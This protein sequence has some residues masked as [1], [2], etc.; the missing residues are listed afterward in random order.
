MDLSDLN[1]QQRTAVE[2]DKGPILVV[3]G[4]G[5]GKTKVITR[6]IAY[7]IETE[8]AKPHEIL[9]LTFTDKAARE[10]EER[11]DTLLPYGLVDTRIM[12]FHSFGQDL[13]KDYGLE[14][15][16]SPNVTL[17][18]KAQQIVFLKDHL[19]N[20][21]L[22]Y[23][24]PISQPDRYLSALASF[25]SRLRE[26]LINPEQYKAYAD[27]LKTKISSDE[28]RLDWLRQSELARAYMVYT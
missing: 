18:S 24:A 28:D 19:D 13:I 26:E 22:E 4:A 14:I 15:G 3:A 27:R 12:T 25:F 7:L 5:T 21:K 8:R 11:V 6:R 9:A 20:M 10:M 1:S 23:Y 2:H 16:L 17:L